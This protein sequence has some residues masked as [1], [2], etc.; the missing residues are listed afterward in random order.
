MPAGFPSSRQ[1]LEHELC[2]IRGPPDAADSSPRAEAAEVSSLERFQ[3]PIRAKILGK[4]FEHLLLVL[5]VGITQFGQLIG[6]GAE[7]P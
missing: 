5:E 6:V 1:A 7:P 2:V 3:G 4:N